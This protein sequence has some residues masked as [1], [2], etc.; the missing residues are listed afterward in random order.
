MLDRILAEGVFD[1]L[2]PKARRIIYLNSR[3]GATPLRGRQSD[4]G[5]PVADVISAL[6]NKALTAR[7]PSSGKGPLAI[8][9]ATHVRGSPDSG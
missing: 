7:G 4:E 6:V 1:D 2:N 5:F 8:F 9:T 3:P